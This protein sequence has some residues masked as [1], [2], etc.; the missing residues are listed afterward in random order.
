MSYL[1]SMN[2]GC[3]T[4]VMVSG[5]PLVVDHEIEYV[6]VD[7][8]G[9]VTGW[10]DRPYFDEDDKTWSCY[11]LYG[12]QWHLATIANPTLEAIETLIEVYP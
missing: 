5:V 1:L 12:E 9:Y 6:T 4:V 11:E 3:S 8:N 2:K 7:K 10:T